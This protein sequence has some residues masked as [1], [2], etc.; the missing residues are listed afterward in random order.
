[1]PVINIK[2]VPHIKK[3]GVHSCIGM[4]DNNNFIS[5]YIIRIIITIIDII[6]ISLNSATGTTKCEDKLKPIWILLSNESSDSHD[7]YGNIVL[8][9]YDIENF[10][11]ISIIV[12]LYYHDKQ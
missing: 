4:G 3:N 5:Q 12:T 11:S 10:S 2:M 9:I 7:I 1:M 6:M 8:A